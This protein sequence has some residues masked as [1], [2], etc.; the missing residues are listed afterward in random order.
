M[1]PSTAVMHCPASL[2]VLSEVRQEA[3]TDRRKY[4]LLATV[5]NIVYI[6]QPMICQ[7]TSPGHLITSREPTG[8]FSL[9]LSMCSRVYSPSSLQPADF[10]TEFQGCPGYIVLLKVKVLQNSRA[11]FFHTLSVGCLAQA[12]WL[13]SVWHYSLFFPCINSA[14]SLEERNS[15]DKGRPYE[16]T[17]L[18]DNSSSLSPINIY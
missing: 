11:Q 15:R 7:P 12:E 13:V 10:L 1:S 4:L 17:N 5:P 8:K 18:L 9:C 16:H 14:G 3:D 2:I 6:P